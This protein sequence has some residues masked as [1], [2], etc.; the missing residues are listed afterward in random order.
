MGLWLEDHY[1][2]RKDAAVVFK[3]LDRATGRVDYIY[4]GNDGTGLPW[5]D[6]AQ[7]DFLKPARRAR[8]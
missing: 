6:T 7:I 2:D 3:R 4:H 1:Y 8:P 5:S